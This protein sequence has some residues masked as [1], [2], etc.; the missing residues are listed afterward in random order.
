MLVRPNDCHLTLPAITRTRRQPIPP[1]IDPPQL[2]HVHLNRLQARERR[3]PIYFRHKLVPPKLSP[4]TRA[5]PAGADRN[6]CRTPFAGQS[7]AALQNCETAR[8]ETELDLSPAEAGTSTL[9]SAGQHPRG[10]TSTSAPEPGQESAQARTSFRSLSL[11]H[12]TTDRTTGSP[13]ST[14]SSKSGSPSQPRC[15]AITTRAAAGT[16]KILRQTGHRS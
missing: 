12:E 8:P 9:R 5:V 4:S 16:Q 3:A 2:G 15:Q 1:G 11:N 6:P 10:R 13:D 14:V 7:A